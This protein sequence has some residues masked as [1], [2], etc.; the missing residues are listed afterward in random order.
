M[1]F[2]QD[3]AGL[4]VVIEDV[5]ELILLCLE[6]NSNI[7][8]AKHRYYDDASV[9]AGLV[10]WDVDERGHVLVAYYNPLDL[11]S[12]VRIVADSPSEVDVDINWTVR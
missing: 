5:N 3:V 10:V 8:R 4:G 9:V 1:D 2:V 12:T 11:A 7:H 6:E